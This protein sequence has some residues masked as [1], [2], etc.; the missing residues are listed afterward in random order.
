VKDSPLP[1]WA[2]G[3]IYQ[4]LSPFNALWSFD[5]SGSRSL[6]VL[7][8]LANASIVAKRTTNAPLRWDVGLDSGCCFARKGLSGSKTSSNDIGPPCT[9]ELNQR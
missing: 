6:I 5:I 8:D 7:E 4:F 9:V 2:N 3:L 1:D